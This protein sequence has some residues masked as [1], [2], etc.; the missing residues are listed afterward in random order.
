M[1]TVTNPH[2]LLERITHFRSQ[3]QTGWLAGYD[4]G[5]TLLEEQ[6]HPTCDDLDQISSD[7]PI[8]IVHVSGHLAVVNSAALKILKS[9]SSQ[10]T[11]LAE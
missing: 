10:K 1:G 6:R 5:D 9:M 11:L 8:A 3:R 7:R 4:Y 2:Q